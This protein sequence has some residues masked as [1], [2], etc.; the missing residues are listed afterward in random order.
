MLLLILWTL[1]YLLAPYG[2]ILLCRRSRAIARI[3]AILMMTI[4]RADISPASIKPG[5]P[6]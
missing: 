1:F 6:C 2:V 4:Y 5:K 3:G